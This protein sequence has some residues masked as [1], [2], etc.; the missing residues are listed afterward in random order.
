[1][2]CAA[3]DAS[4]LETLGEFD[5]EDDTAMTAWLLATCGHA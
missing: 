4:T 1:M 2:A 3:T 5:D